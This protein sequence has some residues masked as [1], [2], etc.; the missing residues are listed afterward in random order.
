M[1]I[2]GKP[3]DAFYSREQRDKGYL[4]MSRADIITVQRMTSL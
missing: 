4:M 1:K 2:K 3:R